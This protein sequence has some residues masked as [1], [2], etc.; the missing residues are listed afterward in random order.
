MATHT[1]R[2]TTLKTR[3]GQVQRQKITEIRLHMDKNGYKGS[4]ITAFVIGYLFTCLP[5][6]RLGALERN[7]LHSSL[8]PTAKHM[9]R[10]EAYGYK[11]WGQIWQNMVRGRCTLVLGIAKSKRTKFKIV[12]LDQMESRLWSFSFLSRKHS[13]EFPNWKK[14]WKSSSPNLYFCKGRFRVE[15]DS[16][17]GHI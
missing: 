8:S 7:V 4:W 13:P 16:V 2:P 6:P 17:W 10:G 9:Y 15:T 3:R 12:A 1:L 11:G 5:L 14:L